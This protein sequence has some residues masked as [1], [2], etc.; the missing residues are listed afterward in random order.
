MPELPEV[1]TI[2][3][4]LKKSVVG[5]R[6]KE[7]V[8]FDHR[9][10]RFPKP[11]E[12]Q[13]QLRG[14]WIKGIERRGKALILEMATSRRKR[15]FLVVQL[16]MTGQLVC[17]A[18]EQKTALTRLTF[19]LCN[20]DHL[21]Y[22]DQRLFGR[23]YLVNDL[24]EISY[25]QSLGPEPLA[26]DF[27]CSGLQERL[28]K[29]STLIKPL[30]LQH[31]FVAGIGNIYASEI[32][33]QAHIHPQRVAKTLCSDEIEKLYQAIRNILA[34]AVKRRGTSM[35]TYRDGYGKRGQFIQ[36]IQVYGRDTKACYRCG[37]PIERMVM[38]GRS[39]FFCRWCQ[40]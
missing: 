37:T 29:K 40:A 38:Q 33:F 15:R 16:M 14:A 35:N 24:N 2:C 5:E 6:I 12:F 8:I 17:S 13:S 9:V 1:E 34:R 26:K 3:R 4:D 22:N 27:V 32:L 25:F 39:T 19:L 20:K 7:V 21:H 36:E 30:L 10:I 31:S 18:Q 11:A 23:L 28:Q